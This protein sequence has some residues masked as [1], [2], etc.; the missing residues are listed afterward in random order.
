VKDGLTR[1]AETNGVFSS[2]PKGR[3]IGFRYRE[4]EP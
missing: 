1:S 2:N 4:M 3:Y